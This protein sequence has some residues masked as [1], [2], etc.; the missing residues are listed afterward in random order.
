MRCLVAKYAEICSVSQLVLLLLVA[1]GIDAADSHEKTSRPELE[2]L[3][4]VIL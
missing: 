3:A 1:F 2:H 4:D